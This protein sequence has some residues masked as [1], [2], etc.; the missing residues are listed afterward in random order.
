M[1]QTYI[2]LK[3]DG[4]APDMEA[5]SG[6][7]HFLDP[8]M[9]IGE[10]LPW[11]LLVWTSLHMIRESTEGLNQENGLMWTRWNI[12]TGFWLGTLG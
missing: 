4:I 5:K 11:P 10:S 1:D 9:P 8:C 6:W 12:Q 7:L 3:V 2:L